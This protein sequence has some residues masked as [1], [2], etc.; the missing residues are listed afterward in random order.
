MADG[1]RRRHP[2]KAPMTVPIDQP[3]CSPGIST[4]PSRCSWAWPW[5]FMDTSQTPTPAP[6]TNSSTVSVA[7]SPANPTPAQAAQA[8]TRASAADHSGRCRDAGRA[9]RSTAWP[10]P[11]RRPSPAGRDRAVPVDASTCA[12]MLGIRATACP[13]LK[14]GEHEHQVDAAD[15][16]LHRSTLAERAGRVGRGSRGSGDSLRTDADRA[17]PTRRPVGGRRATSRGSPRARGAQDRRRAPETQ[18]PH[19]VPARP[20][21]GGALRGAAPACRDHAGRAPRQRRLRA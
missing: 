3:A 5:T 1:R 9:R 6:A 21:A 19:P 15:P 7:G 4:R 14:P 12:L 17:V 8:T 16:V 18:R 2:P 13:T 11:I 20:G 10:A